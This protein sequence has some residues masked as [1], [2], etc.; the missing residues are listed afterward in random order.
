M[1]KNKNRQKAIQSAEQ[2]QKTARE[3]YFFRFFSTLGGGKFRS[4]VA[5]VD[6]AVDD[7]DADAATRRRSFWMAGPH[8]EILIRKKC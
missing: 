8:T 3:V 2:R 4:S 5:A 7:A 1:L 6:D